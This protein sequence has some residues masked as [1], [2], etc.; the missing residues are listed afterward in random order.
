M[1]LNV[2]V[3]TKCRF[4]WNSISYYWIEFHDFHAFFLN[5]SFFKYARVFSLCINTC[6]WNIETHIKLINIPST[7]AHETKNEKI[8][9]IWN[10][11]VFDHVCYTRHTVSSQFSLVFKH[12]QCSRRLEFSYLNKNC[13][14]VNLNNNSVS[15][16][17]FNTHT[18]QIYYVISVYQ[19]NNIRCDVISLPLK[20]LELILSFEFIDYS[21]QTAIQLSHI[22]PGAQFQSKQNI[23]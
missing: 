9:R 11:E 12:M 1:I 10:C 8:P 2:L 22:S 18:L 3:E 6:F 5:F 14:V 15:K 16:Y 4:R 13:T 23:K 20:N 19:N 7:W 21:A 17:D